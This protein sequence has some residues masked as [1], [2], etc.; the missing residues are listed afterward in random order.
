MRLPGGNALTSRIIQESGGGRGTADVASG[1]AGHLTSIAGR[2][3][4]LPV[5]WP[6]LGIPP[7]LAAGALAVRTAASLYADAVE[8]RGRARRA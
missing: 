2:D 8:H 1:G 4:V 5:A 7:A 3:L 6:D